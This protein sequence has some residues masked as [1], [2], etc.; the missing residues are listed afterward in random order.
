MYT[1]TIN[2]F[3]TKKYL[4]SISF[5]LICLL[6]NPPTLFAQTV[7]VRGKVVDKADKQPIIGA[8]VI[9][10]DK[11]GRTV[12]GVS[13]DIEGN[14]L[15]K[16]TNKDFRITISY[17][18]YKTTS[19]IVVGEKAVLNFQMESSSKAIEDVVIR[20]QAKVN[21]G[22]MTI[23]KRDQASSTYTIQ[24]KDLEEM[25]AA[26]IDQALQGRMP[27]VD[28][29]ATSGDPG[30]PMQIRIRGTSSINGITEPL[31][32][33]DGMP[34]ETQI[35][36]DFNFA[37]SDENNYAQLLNIAPAD[38]NTITVLKDAA[39]T[40]IYGARAANGVLV[41]TT[42]RGTV[43]K[44]AIQY[45]FKGSLSKQP[46][47]IPTLNGDQYSTLV[48]E[49]FYNSNT[50]FAT[51]EFAKQFQYDKNDPYNYY[52][53]SSN[54]NWLDAIT[55]LGN[56]QDHNVS[57]NG[58][59]Q[60]ARYMTS[61]NFF[62]N[63]GTTIGTD[64]TRVT[65]RV[66][67]DYA[68]SSRIS[69]RSDFSYTHVNNSR[70][71]FDGD[72]K[73]LV[74]DVAY[75]KMPNQ[76]IYEYDEY[77]NF[78][79]NYFSPLTSAQGTYSGTYNPLA[80]ASTAINDVTQERII[81]K[82][83][84]NYQVVPGVLTLV[85][86]L[87]IDINNS[88]T[89]SFLP[90]IASGRLF[91]ETIVNSAGDSDQDN[92]SIDTKT[93]L[94]FNPKLSEKH[95]LS[96]LL[97]FQTHD[98][99]GT[100][101]FLGSTN[102]A[103]S[104]LQ[105]PVISSRNNYSGSAG[106]GSSQY[107]WVALLMQGNYKYLDR[108]IFSASVRGDGNSRFGQESR[109]GIFP[110]VSARWRISGEP[111]MRKAT[112]FIDDLSLRASW[113]QIGNAPKNNYIFYNNYESY[114]FSYLG[115]TGVYA[116]NIE[117]TNLKWETKTSSNIAIDLSMFKNRFGISLEAYK[118]RSSDL[119][120]YDLALA[121]YHGY[122]NIDM[123]AGVFDN[124]G[125]EASF[126]AN[127]IRKKKFRMDFGFNLAFNENLL[128][129]VSDLLPREAVNSPLVNGRFRTYFQENNPFGSFYGLRY[130]GVYSTLDATIARDKEGNI[131]KGPD[132]NNVYMK[133]GTAGVS[134]I[135]QPGDAMYEDINF[136]GLIDY[137]DVVYLGNGNPKL[138]GGFGP[139]FT[140]NGNLKLSAYFSFRSG[141]DIIN[142]SKMNSTSM[143]NFNNQSTAVLRRWRKEG[144]V[145]D[146]PRALYNRGFN[147]VGSSRYVEDGSFLRL[148]SL[149]AR[150]DFNQ[151]L[152]KKLRL[153]SFGM[154]LTAE[155]VATWT[156]YTGQDPEVAI[157]LNGPSS[158]VIDNSYTPP[159]STY[160]LGLTARF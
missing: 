118:S 63:R 90:Q 119:F 8:S 10:I 100:G 126:T 154:Y 113:G 53:F 109:Y 147:F 83:Q 24:A 136:D 30:A 51:S 112:K 35:P 15:L 108:Y 52:N 127:P 1:N 85:S 73:T 141:Y 77:G 28:I 114:G 121:S 103:S 158:I 97:S 125:W 48:A 78:S 5:L 12:N 106:A 49:E 120:Y 135:F 16:V 148:R 39:A 150:Y 149:T 76:S 95:E 159:S 94:L 143:Y 82:F 99:R 21:D 37:T 11:D 23:A 26:S 45:T 36:S 86:D 70:N 130:K 105:D 152:A 2:R 138:T 68:V 32:I 116:S 59:G 91:T 9:L 57:I 88:K 55:Q 133:I 107:R 98:E 54:T 40:A 38:I 89:K 66:N 13:T 122:P 153:K 67:L 58:G 75:R 104:F 123:N 102:T 140:L 62:D 111:F 14:Y 61:V 128:V 6:L 139:T 131:I 117:L 19:P 27:G 20:S 157:K 137:K 65:A 115:Q 84:L 33:V 151:S 3:M 146:I 155:N 93:N 43:G 145:T 87:Q 29:A 101:Q 160:T 134:Y 124:R 41:I 7:T 81:P 132:G 72:N 46:A 4:F 44:P 142:G 80:F 31:I 69:F 56:M 50:Q 47:A 17:L 18:G 60:K 25:Q 156:N 110:A 92:F 74:R 22:N 144:D 71:F 42:K 34:Y 79:G 96:S 64:L 129:E